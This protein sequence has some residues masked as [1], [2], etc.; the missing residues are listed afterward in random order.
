MPTDSFGREVDTRPWGNYVVLDDHD[1][2]Y[3]VKRIEVTPGRRLSYQRHARRA[4]HWVVISGVATVIL[5]GQEITLNPG[6]CVDI[7][8]G[9][10]HRCENRGTEPVVFVEVQTGTYFGED[11]ITRLEDDYGRTDET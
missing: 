10:A 9:A 11:D 4:E 2:H 1:E 8:L 7:P 5:D 3:K 6:Q